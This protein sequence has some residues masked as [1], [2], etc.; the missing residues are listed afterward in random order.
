MTDRFGLTANFT[1][2]SLFNDFIRDTTLIDVPLK[3]RHFTWSNDRPHPS[4]SKIDRVFIDPSL[5][6]QFP[7]VSLQALPQTVSDHAPLVLTYTNELSPKR[8][9][10]MELF[11]LSNLEAIKIIHEAW[12][13]QIIQRDANNITELQSSSRSV[14][15]CTQGLGHGIARISVNWRSSYYFVTELFCSLIK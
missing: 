13:A 10:K 4:H 7:I 9:F 5:S 6:L 2:M 12:S 14:T 1:F 15:R 8:S 3:N 11:W